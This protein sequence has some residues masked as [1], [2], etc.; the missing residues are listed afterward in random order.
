MSDHPRLNP[1]Q[2]EVLNLLAAHPAVYHADYPPH[3]KL[4]DLGFAKVGRM[5]FNPRDGSGAFEDDPN[6]AVLVITKA[7]EAFAEGGRH[8]HY[9]RA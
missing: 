8:D 3:Q 9:T 2:R 4:I 5:V 1:R 7:G 6:G